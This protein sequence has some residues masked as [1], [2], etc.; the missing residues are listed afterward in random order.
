MDT[1]SGADLSLK[2]AVS[3]VLCVLRLNGLMVFYYGIIMVLV[4]RT[5]QCVVQDLD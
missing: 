4:W 5:Y 3:F 2:I 1:S